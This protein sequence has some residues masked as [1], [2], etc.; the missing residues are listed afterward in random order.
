M[1]LIISLRKIIDM[2][3]YQK[4]NEN[5]FEL[6]KKILAAIKE[7]KSFIWIEIHFKINFHINLYL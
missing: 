6:K 2:P 1:C 3:P 7:N 4:L 5:F